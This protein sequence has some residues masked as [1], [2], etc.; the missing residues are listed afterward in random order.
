M[1]LAFER[2]YYN[3]N[4]CNQ[5]I[6][7]PNFPFV[8]RPPYQAGAGYA[9]RIRSVPGEL[10][11]R[12]ESGCL[13]RWEDLL[14]SSADRRPS[15]ESAQNLFVH[16]VGL[17]EHQFAEKICRTLSQPYSKLDRKFADQSHAAG[18]SN[19]QSELQSNAIADEQSSEWESCQP[20]SEPNGNTS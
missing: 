1:C 20:G 7:P 10:H 3:G 2:I 13:Q 11:L 19:Q 12:K 4:V 16:V 17:G 8:S 15:S 14:R 6:F 5:S 9:E 18:Q